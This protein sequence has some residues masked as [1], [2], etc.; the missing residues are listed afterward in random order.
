MRI[1]VV[2]C[3]GIAMLQSVAGTPAAALTVELAKKCRDPAIKAHPYKMVGERGPGTA[4]AEHSYF[5]E[6]VARQG[7]MRVEANGA[8]QGASGQTQAPPE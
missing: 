3:V 8:G 4:Q 1:F 5:D 7:N 6:C 2:I